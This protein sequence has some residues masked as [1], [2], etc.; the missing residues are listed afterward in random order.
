MDILLI[1]GVVLV[2]L[3]HK[4][5]AYVLG[6][7]DD[8]FPIV[9]KTAKVVT[10]CV[11]VGVAV[12]EK[13]A[14]LLEKAAALLTPTLA[15]LWVVSIGLTLAD[16]FTPLEMASPYLQSAAHCGIWLLAFPAARQFG[17][18][19]KWPRRLWQGSVLLAAAACLLT[20]V[21]IGFAMLYAGAVFFFPVSRWKTTYVYFQ[22]GKTVVADQQQKIGGAKTRRVVLHPVTPLLQ[23]VELLP[24]QARGVPSVPAGLGWVVVNKK[25]ADFSFDPFTQL[26]LNKAREIDR[27]CWANRRR[28]DSLAIRGQLP[29]EAR[30]LPA[31]TRHGANTVG[32]LAGGEV[33]RNY[34]IWPKP[35]ECRQAGAVGI[36]RK[37][38]SGQAGVAFSLSAIM[39]VGNIYRYITLQLPELHGP[40]VYALTNDKHET[41]SPVAAHLM[42]TK[43]KTAGY[44]TT[45]EDFI[46]T[47]RFPGTVTITRF[48]TLARVVSGTF[49]GSVY[50]VSNKVGPLIIDQ[51]R[52]DVKYLE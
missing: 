29:L 21:Y 5:Y 33:W 7:L 49:E 30:T 6:F 46:T 42:L 4:H 15:S 20:F 23:W 38:Q 2:L 16:W 37:L 3:L 27:Q 26:D 35:G 48:D 1:T 8:M 9:G 11:D 18:P 19:A 43:Q 10:R 31:A 50:D 25:A 51:G 32:C 24:Y 44:S 45:N 14:A 36:V 17:W 22:R 13:A 12:V 34:L 39:R 40:G 41:N 52:F 47:K 28:I